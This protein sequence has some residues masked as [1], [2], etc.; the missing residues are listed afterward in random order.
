[1][2]A[3]NFNK[4]AC[5]SDNVYGRARLS[6][7]QPEVLAAIALAGRQLIWGLHEYQIGPNIGC[8]NVIGPRKAG[9]GS[10][11]AGKIAK[12]AAET[13]APRKATGAAE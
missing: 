7:T 5:A 8:Q 4:C 6:V 10:D 13:V 1:M 3:N 12:S 9:P 2:Q 11:Y